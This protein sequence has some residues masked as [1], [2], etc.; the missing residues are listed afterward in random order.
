MFAW[1]ALESK[2]SESESKWFKLILKCE[3]IKIREMEM[4]LHLILCFHL[5]H[6]LYQSS[7]FIHCHWQSH[8]DCDAK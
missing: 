5:Q 7:L 6:I 2:K 1:D 4:S 8:T 3:F